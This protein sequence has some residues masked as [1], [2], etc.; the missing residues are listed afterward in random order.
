LRSHV[1]EEIKYIVDRIKGINGV[2]AIVLFG[3]YSRGDFDEGSDI[4][5][6]VVFR[7]KEELKEGTKQV[8]NISA[9]SDYFFQIVCLTLDELR[10]S[11]LL[12]SILRE[13]K[14]YY[15]EDILRKLSYSFKPYA[16]I[17]YSTA[18]LSLKE[19]ALIAQKL[20]GRV[21]NKYKY[22][23]L[24]QQLGGYK[25]GRGVIMVPI[26]NLKNLIEFLDKRKVQYV[27]RYVWV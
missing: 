5:L 10:N 22:D 27:I 16:L 14:I 4:D 19:R 12:S 21:Y 26:E 8:Y 1:Y 7:N 18:N 3:S 20:E 6:L 15:G 24:V 25:V 17:T 9:K 23:G 11:P 13:G 2:L